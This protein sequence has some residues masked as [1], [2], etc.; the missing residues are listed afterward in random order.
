VVTGFA[1]WTL[2][3]LVLLPAQAAAPSFDA[4]TAGALLQ[5]ANR[6]RSDK[7]L[8]PLSSE[9]HLS[10]AAARFAE[11]MAHHDRYG[12]DADGRQ[13]AQRVQ[14]QGYAYCLV[15]ENIAFAASTAGF[16]AAGLA[17]QLFDGWVDSP[18][19]RHNLLDAEYTETGIATAYSERSNRHYAVQLFGRPRTLVLRFAL[20]NA[21]ADTVRYQL[22]GRDYSLPAGIVRSHE[23]CRGGSLQ[24]A[25][26]NAAIALAPGA[27]Y[28][29]E[30]TG[31]AMRIQ[32]E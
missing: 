16:D 4:A 2:L 12:H 26:V 9:P 6:L 27:R 15:A 30:A 3:W 31:G 5:H 13:P 1:Q 14:T 24:V 20:A 23:Q 10:A 8:G 11:F 19:H 28:R 25:G 32:R 18:P 22:A 17:R 7:G 21:T 29:I